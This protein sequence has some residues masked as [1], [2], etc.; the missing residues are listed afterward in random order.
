MELA[1]IIQT[2]LGHRYAAAE[3]AGALQRS[4]NW[5]RKNATALGG[6]KVGGEWLFFE[7]NIVEAL[8]RTNMGGLCA[9]KTE[10][11]A[12]RKVGVVCTNRS[13]GWSQ[14]GEEVP[15]E[16]DG[17]GMGGLDSA[18]V[19]RV[20]LDADPCNLLAQPD[21]RASAGS[22]SKRGCSGDIR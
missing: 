1:Q 12:D 20:L 6:V 11:Q 18:E 4:A 13:A 10:E 15:F 19:E 5:V 21:D 8:R 9:G 17:N 7:N 16:E 22:Q 3:V 14:E 2:N